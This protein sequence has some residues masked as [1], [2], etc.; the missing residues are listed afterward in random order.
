MAKAGNR[1]T[2]I[3][4]THMLNRWWPALLALSLALF[5][6]AFGVSR[7]PEGKAQPFIT[8]AVAGLGFVVLIMAL[9][10]LTIRKS[11]YVQPFRTHLRLV[12]P[13]LRL[14]I[15]YRRFRSSTTSDMKA[16]FPPANIS[17][18]RR[19]IIAPLA[20]MTSIVINLNGFP[21]HPFLLRFFLSPFF[22][23]DKTPHLII[24]V[25]D[26]MRFSAELESM[27]TGSDED[28]KPSQ[29]DGS[30]LSRLPQK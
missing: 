24:L 5:A 12:T 16:L 9:F 30:I 7:T 27:R 8:T 11:A 15:S 29:R 4:Y 28:S 2:L 1:Y 20:P 19:G 22:F 3:L 26:W 25:N 21:L 23:K 17:G 6:L 18:W 14:N 13:F 10:F